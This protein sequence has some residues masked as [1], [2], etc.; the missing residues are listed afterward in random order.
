MIGAA[1][2]AVSLI[3]AAFRR[4]K[5]FAFSR[6]VIAFISATLVDSTAA[7]SSPAV[8]LAAKSLLLD[9]VNT[10]DKIVAVGDHGN[11]VISHDDGVNWKQSAA[12]TGVL[13][14]AVSFPDPQNGWAVGHE[15]VI[16][17]TNDGGQNW[18]RQDDGKNRERVLLDV[19]FISANA[20]FAFGAYGIALS[21][22]DG[23]KTWITIK[24]GNEE[25]HYNRV[26]SGQD[27]RLYVAGESST[28]LISADSGKSWWKADVPYDGSLFGAL[29]VDRNSVIVY[30]LRGHIFRSEDR[31]LSWGP[32]PSNLT[33]LITS[34]LRLKSGP[35]ILGGQGGNF[36]VSRD[37]GRSFENWKPADFGTSIAGMV[38][39]NDGSIITVGEAGAVRVRLP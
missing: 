22:N 36:F 14:T 2:R 6:L 34:G 38:E 24:P 12:P 19:R 25:V 27:G 13:L 16:L 10:G 7:E 3:T 28:L 5:Y 8:P 1:G 33:I 30:G 29:P 18:K 37:A 20:G 39:A 21:T 23:G 31:G 17:A 32:V 11:I 4:K 15:G 35:V 9:A 26:T